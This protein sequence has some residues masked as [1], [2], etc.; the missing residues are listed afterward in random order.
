MC[1]HMNKLLHDNKY[2]ESPVLQSQMVDID[3]VTQSHNLQLQYDSFMSMHLQSLINMKEGR[4]MSCSLGS[5]AS[6]LVSR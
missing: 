4:A 3:Q 6:N 5:A 2:A 1:I